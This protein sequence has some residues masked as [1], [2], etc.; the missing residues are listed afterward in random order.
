MNIYSIFEFF[1]LEIAQLY[2]TH[3]TN[4]NSYAAS[5]SKLQIK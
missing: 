2:A 5:I 1:I 3:I 4:P